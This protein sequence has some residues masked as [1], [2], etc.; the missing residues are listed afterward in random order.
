MCLNFQWHTSSKQKLLYFSYESK[1]LWNE[2]YNYPQNRL[3]VAKKAT[4]FTE[5]ASSDANKRGFSTPVFE[6][7]TNL[8]YDTLWLSLK[9]EDY[10]L[11]SHL[12]KADLTIGFAPPNKACKLNKTFCGPIRVPFKRPSC[13]NI[14]LQHTFMC[15]P[16]ICNLE[17]IYYFQKQLWT[18]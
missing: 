2:K 6:L 8:I 17:N 1:K 3:R 10:P 9:S 16:M 7:I 11:A 18:T 4:T 14:K 15:P 12:K 5:L 13:D